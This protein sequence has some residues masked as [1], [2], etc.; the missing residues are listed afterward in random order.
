M[1]DR[2]FLTCANGSV[3]LKDGHY[4]L[5]LPFRRNDLVRPNNRSVAEQRLL[6]LKRK[7]EK[8]E[9][10]KK[11]YI[12]FMADVIEK[13]YAEV[14]PSEQLEKTDG[15]V[16]YIPH[17]GVYHPKRQTLRVVFDCSASYQGNT[18]VTRRGK[19]QTIYTS[20]KGAQVETIR[21]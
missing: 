16:W 5:D 1:E 20:G 19:T 9:H 11:E 14:V 3:T 21:D 2:K 17:H 10:F 8:N 15:R 12:N 4:Y 6:G 18:L 13:G 7:L